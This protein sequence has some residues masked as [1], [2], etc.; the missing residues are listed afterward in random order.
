ML[1]FFTHTQKKGEI[2]IRCG[3]IIGRIRKKSEWISQSFSRSST[4]SLADELT[5]EGCDGGTFFKKKIKYLKLADRI[6]FPL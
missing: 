3:I 2:E 4:G 6:F 1:I 5:G